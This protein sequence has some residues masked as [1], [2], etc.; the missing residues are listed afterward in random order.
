MV[1]PALANPFLL[2]L[3]STEISGSVALSELLKRPEVSYDNLAEIDANRPLLSRHARAQIA[4]EIK[5]SGYIEK[6]REQVERFRKLENRLL[7]ED[8]DYL[9]MKG[10]RIEA[11]QKLDAQRPESIGRASRISGVSPADINVLLVYLEKERRKK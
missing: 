4:V 6:Q 3:G 10:L 1:K 11:A 5:Y 2:S 9:N 7:P 8:L